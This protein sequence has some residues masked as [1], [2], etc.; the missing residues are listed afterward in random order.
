MAA[1]YSR[2]PMTHTSPAPTT[3][4]APR[5][6][7]RR[8]LLA[9]LVAL[10][11]MAG[12]GGLLDGVLESGDL[13]RYDPGVT[14]AV[15]AER[16]SVLTPIAQGLTLLGSVAFL[17]PASAVLLIVLLVRR[18][19]HAAVVCG[20]ALA[21]ALGVTVMMKLWVARDRPNP[22]DVLGAIDASYAF[23]SGHSAMGT[24]FYGLL[25]ALL[26]L[27]TRRSGLRALVIAGW[28]LLAVGIGTSRVYLGYHWMTDVLGGWCLGL[29]VLGLA[30]A[31]ALRWPQKSVSPPG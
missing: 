18:R 6:A 3:A 21:V 10:L 19:F 20:L 28:L 4:R 26:V 23:P 13:S 7:D 24:V 27:R 12:L 17:A 25:A 5:R 16:S 8:T 22:L 14:E 15:I 30:A 29:A 1:S 2:P 9:V 11:A 31:L